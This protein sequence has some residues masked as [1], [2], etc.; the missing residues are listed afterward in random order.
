MDLVSYHQYINLEHRTDRRGACERQLESIGIAEPKRFNAIK[1]ADGIVGCGLSH[2]CCLK[3]AKAN[4][5]PY[6]FVCEDDAVF[7]QPQDMKSKLQ[8]LATKQWDVAL[9]GGNVV[10]PYKTTGSDARQISKCL[11]TTAYIVRAHY[12]DELIVCWTTALN[13]LIRTRNRD[14]SLDVAW[15]DLQHRDT[16]LIVWP[17][18]VHQACS[19]SDIE[20]RVVD[21]R[22]LMGMR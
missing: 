11:T 8:K 21:Y 15:F 7:A 2:L 3:H 22:A 6:V 17:L 20:N 19:Y 16:W 9:L 12:Y 18:Q 10:G 14:F 1:T 5:W 13:Q 4:G